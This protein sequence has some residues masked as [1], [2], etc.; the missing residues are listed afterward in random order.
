MKGCVFYSKIQN[1]FSQQTRIIY[2]EKE[3][4]AGLKIKGSVRE[5]WKGGIGLS[6][7]EFHLSSGILSH[8]GGARL[9]KTL[10]HLKYLSDF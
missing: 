5:K 9:I 1:S 3:F 8:R 7:I 2:E 4:T 6:L 10:F